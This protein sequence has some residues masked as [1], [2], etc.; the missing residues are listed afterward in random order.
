MEMNINLPVPARWVPGHRAGSKILLD[1]FNVKMWLKSSDKKNKYYICTRKRDLECTVRVTV[2]MEDDMI[3]YHRGEHNHDSY[4]LKSLVLEKR[5]E[6]VGKAVQNKTISP[7]TAFMD[8]TNK[9]MSDPGGNLK[10][11]ES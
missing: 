9:V 7:R 10:E 5:Q 3:V 11:E 8:L 6:V 4:I 2:R 1:P